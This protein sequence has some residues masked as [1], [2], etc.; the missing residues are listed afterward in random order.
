MHCA[1]CGQD[2]PEGAKFCGNCRTF[3]Q[4][5]SAPVLSESDLTQE[6]EIT[7]GI[8]AKIAYIALFIWG[9]FLIL[10]GISTAFN[11]AESPDLPKNQF[12]LSGITIIAA[13]VLTILAGYV[14]WKMRSFLSI[15]TNKVTIFIAIAGFIIFVI[16]ISIDPTV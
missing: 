6:N 5:Q 13:G 2:N 9:G 16:G 8:G 10:G 1:N 11:W 15:G 3:F 12:V 4:N 7:N 14:R